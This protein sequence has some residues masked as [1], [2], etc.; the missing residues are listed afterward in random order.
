MPFLE[1]HRRAV[2]WPQIRV[3]DSAKAGVDNCMQLYCPLMRFRGNGSH[4]RL[5]RIGNGC[6]RALLSLLLASTVA[7]WM[8]LLDTEGDISTSAIR[9]IEGRGYEAFLGVPSIGGLLY[10]DGDS[11]G[12][13]SASQLQLFEDGRR[14][15][16]P[17][18]LHRSVN[19]IGNGLYSHWSGWL[20]FSTPDNSDPRTNGR[21]YSFV[22][23]VNKLP[24][25]ILLGLPLVIS[26]V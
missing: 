14:F 7:L 8:G 10:S 13:P 11:N 22:L 23:P 4:R 15:G 1:C 17:H 16:T 9:P 20:R 21:R 24:V 26:L 25:L 3:P 2:A 6:V 5:H 18:A 12:S 19:E